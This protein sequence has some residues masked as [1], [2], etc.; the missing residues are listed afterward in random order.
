MWWEKKSREIERN[1]GRKRD[2]RT[3]IWQIW[4]WIIY[5]ETPILTKWVTLHKT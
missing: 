5:V 1:K 3:N 2:M 4:K